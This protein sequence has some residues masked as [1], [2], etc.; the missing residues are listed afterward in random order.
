MRARVLAVDLEAQR[1]SLGLKASYLE[2]ADEEGD[3]VDA[4]DP[5]DLDAEAAEA[6]GAP[7][8]Y[9][10]YQPVCSG[11]PAFNSLCVHCFVRI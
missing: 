2:G 7:Q 1:L 4:Q 10:A 5:V 8:Q 9:F 6:V 3:D 11:L